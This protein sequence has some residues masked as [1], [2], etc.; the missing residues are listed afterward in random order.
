[1]TRQ[2]FVEKKR[3]SARAKERISARAKER[4]SARAKER[5]SARALKQTRN[6]IDD[7]QT[8]SKYINKLIFL[9]EMPKHF[10]DGYT[11]IELGTKKD[12]KILHTYY[13]DDYKL[14]REL[15]TPHVIVMGQNWAKVPTSQYFFQEYNCF[16][17]NPDPNTEFKSDAEYHKVI[18]QLEALAARYPDIV[19]SDHRM[20]HNAMTRSFQR[21]TSAIPTEE[22]YRNWAPERETKNFP[23]D[24]SIPRPSGYYR[25]P[26]KGSFGWG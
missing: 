2:D 18:E 14:P 1:V 16:N 22:R 26:G 8:Q 6:F 12:G 24:Y 23:D 21:V 11:Q 5:I 4:I 25:S 3:I 7:F 19:M 20:R 17:G 13:I 10:I 15:I 9:G